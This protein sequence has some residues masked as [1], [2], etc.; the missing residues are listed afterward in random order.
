VFFP[1]KSSIILKV[2]KNVK[3]KGKKNEGNK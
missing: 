3:E 2:D 1:W